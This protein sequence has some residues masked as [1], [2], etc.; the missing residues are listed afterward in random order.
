MRKEGYL[1]I[2]LILLI[3]SCRNH[4]PERSV[5]MH[6]ESSDNQLE[7]AF[8]WA[9][10]QAESYTGDSADPVGPWYE[11]ALPGREAFCARDMAHM[12]IGAEMLGLGSENKN[13]L[14]KF[15]THISKS[16]DWCTYWEINRSDQPAPADYRNDKAI[17]YN[18][19]ANFDL[20]HASF[21][22]F[23]FTGD[24]TYI[25]D[26]AIKNFREKS[27]H[28]YVDHWDLNS[29]KLM[30]RKRFMHLP[31]DFD[32]TDAFM[33][34]RGL[35]GYV[36]SV[37]GLQLGADLIAAEY[38]ACMDASRIALVENDVESADNFLDQAMDLKMLLN[39]HWWDESAERFYTSLMADGQFQ[40]G[41]GE[42]FLLWFGIANAGRKTDHTIRSLMEKSDVMNVETRS[43]LPLILF[44]NGF[45]HDGYLQILKLS[46]PAT[47]RREYPEV[48]FSVIESMI[49][50]LMG[51]DADATKNRVATCS[52]LADSTSC[53][54]QS[55]EILGN[56]ISVFHRGKDLT[57]AA[58]HGPGAL[59]WKV[60]F[61]GKHLVLFVD[62]VQFPAKSENQGRQIR[63]Y[64]SLTIPPGKEM[65]V[66]IAE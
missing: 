13:M 34:C 7:Q 16:K 1:I 43:Y 48:S 8:N 40:H 10:N 3:S 20:V 29:G 15:A 18:L 2:L 17:W 60:C 31:A 58:N 22:L 25:M 33:V 45:D 52:H 14:L 35:P 50:G 19:P 11:A 56:R 27:L 46:D 4:V 12:C 47:L 44:E 63:S 21:R 9:V 6:F 57:Q 36:E 30:Y 59:E 51:I 49:S 26:P 64:V 53:S 55:L 65:T 54:I 24:S 42:A 28:Q 61:Q 5:Q 62:G 66:S 23:R 39:N 32:S 37:P 38:A 41:E